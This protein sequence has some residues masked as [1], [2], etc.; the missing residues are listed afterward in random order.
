MFSGQNSNFSEKS[1]LFGNEKR[2]SRFKK[3]NGNSNERFNYMIKTPNPNY[4]EFV[5]DF[6]DSDGR[7]YS[8]SNSKQVHGFD[9]DNDILNAE[10]LSTT[11]FQSWGNQILWIRIP[12]KYHNVTTFPNPS[13][14]ELYLLHLNTQISASCKT[15]KVF[16][17]PRSATG[18]V[19][20]K[21]F[22]TNGQIVDPS[23]FL[24]FLDKTERIEK[25]RK[26]F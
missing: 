9:I 7:E 15:S 4:S 21:N 12:I 13:N 6:I 24:P 16:H 11:D 3:I 5:P 26:L 23:I 14:E 8:I 19:I 22:T 18:Y 1:S 10:L 25:K 20:V 17:L 2:K